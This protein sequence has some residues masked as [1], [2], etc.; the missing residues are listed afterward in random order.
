MACF[1]VKF[2][3]AE[4]KGRETRYAETRQE[5]VASLRREGI[6]VISVEEVKDD[7]DTP[8]TVGL[9][10]LK[11]MTSLDREL[12]FQQL[13]SML[14]SGVSIL[15][16]LDTVMKQATSYISRKVWRQISEDVTSGRSLS[17]ALARH[18]KQFDPVSVELVRVGEESGELD[19]A[20]LHAAEEMEARRSLK[21]MV[22]NALIYPVFAIAMAVAVT[23]FL[24]VDVIPKI[25]DFLSGGGASLPL[26]TQTLLNVSLWLREYGLCIIGGVMLVAL[27]IA[28]IRIT[29]YGKLLT[30]A[31]LLKIPVTGRISKL[32]GTAL[33]ARAMNMLTNSGVP[34][35]NSLE[36]TSRL[37]TNRVMAG[38]IKE[39]HN[40]VMAGKPLAASLKKC[41]EF[42]PMLSVMVAVGESTG[43]LAESF[44]EV[45]KFHGTMLEITIKRFSVIIEPVLISITGGIVGFV[46]IAFFMALFSMSNAG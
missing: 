9:G 28:V 46:Y 38:R 26:L 37:I 34:L 36:V 13:A 39:I 40:A 17:E 24:V 3:G 10:A 45:A 6:A 14:K 29:E 20:L 41:R 16:A 21:T 19:T 2:I 12:G 42:M 30:D 35:L 25:A 32:A 11:P 43:T 8:Y 23:V 18:V 1:K 7:E 27:L 31:I 15:A 44:F 4:G 5:L 33:F 22:I